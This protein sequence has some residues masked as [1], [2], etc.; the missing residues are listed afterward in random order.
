[1]GHDRHVPALSQVFALL[2]ALVH[3]LVFVLESVLWMRPAVH[4]R[5]LVRSRDHA[6]LLRPLMLNQGF[7]NLFLAAGILAGLVM[8]RAGRETAGTAVVVFCC[9]SIVAA[10]IVLLGTER[11]LLR[12]ALV[13]GVPAALALALLTL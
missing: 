5:F 8:L 12:A 13:Q 11:R 4:R 7:Y 10:A 2:A 1:L 9:A 3:V 6:G